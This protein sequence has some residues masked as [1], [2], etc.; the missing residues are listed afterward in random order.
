MITVI[1][2]LATTTLATMILLAASSGVF[3]YEQGEGSPE[4]LQFDSQHR[5]CGQ[6]IAVTYVP[7]PSLQSPLTGYYYDDY[8]YVG[9]VSYYSCATPSNPAPPSP[10]SCRARVPSPT[11]THA[12]LP[13]VAPDYGGEGVSGGEKDDANYVMKGEHGGY[14]ESGW[15]G[16]W[17]CDVR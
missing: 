7:H 5:S 3:A 11:S 8:G 4:D 15:N 10:H 14:G 6:G 17:C 12:A 1:M 13:F 9:I 2:T 16:L